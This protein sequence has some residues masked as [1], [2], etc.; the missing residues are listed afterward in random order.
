[1]HRQA[2]PG[3]IP[4]GPMSAP[5][6]RE[7]PSHMTRLIDFALLLIP[8][9]ALLTITWITF[10]RLTPRNGVIHPFVKS[11]L[12]CNLV[13]FAFVSG[14]AIGLTMIVSGLAGIIRP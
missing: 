14:T 5:Q 10:S 6:A 13:L 3:G 2:M 4:T 9:I 8:G 11:D 12:N 1:M 7:S